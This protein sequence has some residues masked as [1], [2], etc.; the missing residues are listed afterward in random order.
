MRI[1]L[2]IFFLII[3]AVIAL[4][5]TE[6]ATLRGTVADPSRLVVPGAEIVVTDLATNIEVRRFISDTNG[7]YEVPDLRPGTYRVKVEMAGFRPYVADSPRLDA[8]QFGS[9][10]RRLASHPRRSEDN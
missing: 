9:L 5:Q 6:K 1:R 3:S 2:L 7:N 8:G 4:A 10:Q